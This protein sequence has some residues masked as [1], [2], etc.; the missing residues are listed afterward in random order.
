MQCYHVTKLVY[1]QFYFNGHNWLANQLEQQ[2][3]AF[4][5]QDNAF[6]EIADSDTANHLAARR[7]D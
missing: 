4:E 1:L 3:V 7:R 2:G 5:Q 6:L